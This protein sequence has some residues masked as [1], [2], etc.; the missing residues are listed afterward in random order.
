MLSLNGRPFYLRSGSLSV[1]PY[2][3]TTNDKYSLTHKIRRTLGVKGRVWDFI[4]ALRG[5]D[6]RLAMESLLTETPSSYKLTF[7]DGLGSSYEVTIDEVGDMTPV[8]DNTDYWDV[9]LKVVEWV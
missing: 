4:V 6:D 7:E 2:T 1:D 9:K 8:V 5:W 3:R